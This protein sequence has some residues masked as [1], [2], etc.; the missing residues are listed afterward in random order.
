MPRFPFWPALAVLLSLLLTVEPVLLRLGV[1]AW[2][3]SSRRAWLWRLDC[4]CARIG[5]S[6]PQVLEARQPRDR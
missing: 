6:K 5:R 3:L 4:G 1:P 2:A